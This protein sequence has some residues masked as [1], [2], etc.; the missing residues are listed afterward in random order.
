[1]DGEGWREGWDCVQGVCTYVLY[2]CSNP[3][4]AIWRLGLGLG[5][6]DWNVVDGLACLCDSA[7]SACDSHWTTGNRPGVR[8][9]LIG[10]G[11]TEV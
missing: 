8:A 6:W 4:I 7:I 9:G 1:M 10:K 11:R 3:V 5:L 2:V